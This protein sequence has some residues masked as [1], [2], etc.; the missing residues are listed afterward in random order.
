M[1]LLGNG[2]MKNHVP[3]QLGRLHL[4]FIESGWY[5][6]KHFRWQVFSSDS[7]LNTVFKAVG[8]LVRPLRIGLISDPK[9]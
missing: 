7:G 4:Q 2:D 8:Q 3:K 1:R 5:D 6:A 9:R